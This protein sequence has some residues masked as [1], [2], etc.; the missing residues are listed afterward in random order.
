MSLGPARS[1][2]SQSFIVLTAI[3][4]ASILNAQV[5]GTISGFVKDP[6]GAIVPGANITAVLTGQQ[7]TRTAQSDSTGFYNM[8]SKRP[9]GYMEM[10]EFGA[11]LASS[12]RDYMAGIREDLCDIFD[13]PTLLSTRTKSRPTMRYASSS[14]RTGNSCKSV[15]GKVISAVA[16]G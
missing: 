5:A 12:K 13:S 14:G 6:S 8:L 16:S 10:S 9:A 7:L 1:L 11:F 2:F 4:A 3:G 15:G